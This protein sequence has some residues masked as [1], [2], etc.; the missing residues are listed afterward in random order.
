[1]QR[2]THLGDILRARG[3]VGA[4]LTPTNPTAALDLTLSR[5][6]IVK[7]REGLLVVEVPGGEPGAWEKNQSVS[8]RLIAEV[9][10]EEAP[11]HCDY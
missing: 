3:G 2:L 7:H 4:T 1:M 6:R 8:V 10:R 11:L 9:A 5:C